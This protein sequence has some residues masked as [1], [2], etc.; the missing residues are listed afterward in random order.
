MMRQGAPSANLWDDTKLRT[1]LDVLE[2][3]TGAQRDLDGLE[4]WADRDL[5]KFNRVLH[6]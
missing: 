1:V 2:G 5:W 3:N 6:L 4:K